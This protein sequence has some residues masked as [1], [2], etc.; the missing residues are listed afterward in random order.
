[1]LYSGS[2]KKIKHSWTKTPLFKLESEG[3][4]IRDS[5]ESKNGS[6]KMEVRL[7]NGK[8]KSQIA[9]EDSESKIDS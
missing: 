4:S 2:K 3:I 6:S 1:M 8:I 7:R 9:Q 5:S